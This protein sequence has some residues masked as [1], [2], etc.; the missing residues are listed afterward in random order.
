MAKKY[1]TEDWVKYLT[2]RFAEEMQAQ[3][4]WI[5]VEWA[6]A[7]HSDREVR[8]LDFACGPGMASDVRYSTSF[9]SS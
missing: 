5:G 4:D 8:M 7:R 6:Q 3:I 2:Q 9:C 1:D